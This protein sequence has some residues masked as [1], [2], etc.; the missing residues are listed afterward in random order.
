M[1]PA[2]SPTVAH[3]HQAVG[4]RLIGRASDAPL[5]PVAIDSRQVGEGDV[6][7]ALPGPNHDG[8]DFVDE[9]FARGACG[10]VADRPIACPEDRWAV[11]VPNTQRALWDWAAWHRRR[12]TGT[13]IAVTGSVGKTTTR[14]MIHTVLSSRLRGTA[15]P[16]NF[17]NHIGLPLSLLAVAP[18]DDYAVLEMGASGPGEIAAL[19]DLC[20]PR[21]GV[22]TQ[23]GDAHLGGFG[24]RRGVAEAK[25]ELL[26]ALPDDGQAV[27]V[28]D[29]WI[30]R[31]AGR[32]RAPITWVGRDGHCDL[33]ADEVRSSEGRLQFKIVDC[34]FDVPVWGRH[35]LGSAL[36]AVA[37][38]RTFGLDLETIA[39][40]LSQFNPLPMRCEVIEVR[41]ATIIN[42]TYNASPTAM[43][44]ALEL[45]RD[46]DT[47]GR[48]VVVCGDMAEL[49]EESVRLHFQLGRQIVGACGADMLIACGQFARQVVDGARAAGMPARWTIPC[50][51]PDEALPHVGQAILPG[52]VVLVKGSRAMNMEHVVDALRQ[53][54]RR[55]S[56]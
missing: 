41:G 13:M 49:G 1:N 43:H 26:A 22:I 25:A 30:H 52:D 11:E 16:R 21:V 36:A 9:A 32:S 23:V 2:V 39:E 4:G 56:A 35:H 18:E 44:A 28:D 45:L 6:F 24:S 54:P 31:V 33:V 3:L 20:R 14:Q 47:P 51:T 37:V 34:P 48:R 42:D 8:A 55:R 10:V 12:F 29:P 38:G 17:N 7:W 53:Y 50:V 27:L 19:A 40:A 5:G 15:S 46:F